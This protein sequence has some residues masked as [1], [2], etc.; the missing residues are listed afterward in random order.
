[1]TF[2]PDPALNGFDSIRLEGALWPRVPFGHEHTWAE[3]KVDPPEVCNECCAAS[4]DYH[5]PACAAEECPRCGDRLV[6]CPCPT[7]MGGVD[8]AGGARHED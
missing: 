6:D 3:L 8:P 4:D 2:T 1:M 7:G 5:E